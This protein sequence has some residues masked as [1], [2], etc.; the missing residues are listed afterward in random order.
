MIAFD[1]KQVGADWGKLSE[2]MVETRYCDCYRKTAVFS[3]YHVF[4]NLT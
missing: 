1:T 4:N 3:N 2:I